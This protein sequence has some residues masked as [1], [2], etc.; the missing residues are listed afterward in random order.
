MGDAASFEE[1]EIK[2]LGFLDNLKK[3]NAERKKDIYVTNRKISELAKHK[4]Y[5]DSLI[6]QV[7]I[8]I[9]NKELKS[10]EIAII[11]HLITKLK[12]H[13]SNIDKVLQ[14]RLLLGKENENLESDLQVIESKIEIK[15]NPADVGRTN[16]LQFGP[17]ISSSSVNMEG[18][19][20]FKTASS[21]LPKLNG[22]VDTVHQLIEGIELY[23]PSLNETNKPLLINFVL[24]ACVPYREK[25]RLKSTYADTISLIADLKKHFLPKQSA[26]ALAARLQTLKQNNLS[27]DDF[28]KSVEALMSD[29]TIA[30][31]GDDATRVDIFRKANEK[32]AIDVF[33]NGIRNTELRTVIKARNYDNLSEAINA[34]KEETV[35]EQQHSQSTFHMRT[36]Q[37]HRQQFSTNFHS[38]R[39]N[40]QNFSKAGNKPAFASRFNNANYRFNNRKPNNSNYNRVRSNFSSNNQTSQGSN[41]RRRQYYPN[42]NQTRTQSMYTTTPTDSQQSAGSSTINSQTF[43]RSFNGEE[44]A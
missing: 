33:A 25:L 34:A 37:N 22:T 28:G 29:L 8:K 1:L 24:K 19:F 4:S 5:L 41:Y 10:E 3:D 38:N 27:I 2:L 30:Q 18:K 40:F 26:P 9:K 32:I 21:L 17:S 6:E 15:E 35:P 39:K 36:K 14:G 44:T 11:Q 23:E 12:V 7:N 43:F 31:S 13:I 42:R 16:L 20:D